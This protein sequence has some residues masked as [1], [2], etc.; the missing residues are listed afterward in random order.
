MMLQTAVDHGLLS[1]FR[2]WLFLKCLVLAFDE[3]KH[4]FRY[5]SKN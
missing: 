5:I 1:L 3:F 2:R 4:Y